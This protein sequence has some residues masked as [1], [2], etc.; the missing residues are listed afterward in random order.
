MIT[1]D[2]THQVLASQ[3]VQ[4]RI[5]HGANDP[6]VPPTTLRQMLFDLLVFFAS[7][8]ESVFGLTSGPPLHDPLAVA[9]VLSTLNPTFPK[10]HPGQALKFD[11]RNG[12]RFTVDVVTEG[13]HGTDAE[14]AGA[15]GQSRVTPT[16]QGVAIPRGVDLAAFWDLIL[17]C[18]QRA[19]D[20]NAARKKAC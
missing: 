4:F 17:L 19:D 1:L 9:V 7:T 14:L 18:L 8:Y 10:Q 12:E 6:S 13:L 3:D 5:L 11:D 15:L 20:C 16:E 2:L